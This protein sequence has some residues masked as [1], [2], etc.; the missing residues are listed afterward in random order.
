MN[1]TEAKQ[2]FKEYLKDYDCTNDKVRLKIV[3]TYGVIAQAEAVARRM[4]LSDE[5]TQLARH[6]ALLHDIGRFEQLKQF[7][8]FESDTMDHAAYG[9]RILF[10]DGLIR[11]FLPEDT[12]DGIIRTAIARHSDYRLPDILDPR[13]QLHA[14]LIRDAD[15]LDNCRVKLED[16]IETFLGASAEEVGAQEISPAIYRTVFENRCILSKDRV[17]KMDYWV[18]YIAY[19]FDIN[20]KESMEI[21]TEN[22]YLRKTVQRIP[23]SNGKTARQMGEIEKHLQNYIETVTGKK[24]VSHGLCSKCTD[25]T[26]L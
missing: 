4:R 10:G 16:D 23:Y 25:L 12:W 26:E 22:D 2:A 18:S 5:D 20:F 24:T 9:V 7:D 3:H 1:F 14:K 17:T 13:T 11:R 8:S 21:I 15:K 19:F 6:I